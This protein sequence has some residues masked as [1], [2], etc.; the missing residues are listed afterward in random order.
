MRSIIG[1]LIVVIL[2]GCKTTTSTPEQA[3]ITPVSAHLLS[4]IEHPVAPLNFDIPSPAQIVE[5]SPEQQQHFL[6]YFNDP[7]R[8]E[9]PRHRRLFQYIDRLY[10]NFN[11]L[12]KTFDAETAMR[13]QSGNC[14]SLAIL[15]TALAELVGLDVGY[16][17]VNVAPVYQ[18]YAS[19][20]TLSTHVRTHL[21]ADAVEEDD[22]IVVLRARIIIDYYPQRSNIRGEMIDAPAF[23]SMYYRN[24][25]S[26]ALIYGRYN[27][28]Y[29]FMRY[30]LTIAPY[31][32]ENLNTMAVTLNKLGAADKALAVYA[33][34][35][36]TAET[37]LNVISN[38][39]DLL[40]TVDK[41]EQ[42]AQVRLQMRRAND[43]NPYRWL[44]NANRAI[45]EG[46]YFLARTLLNKAL[47]RAPY[48]HEAYFSLAKSYYLSDEHEKADEALQTAAKLAYLPETE[49]LYEAKRAVLS[50][51]EQ[52]G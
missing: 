34:A 13:E 20:M 5:L 28:A 35:T 26:D 24:L 42:A 44:D 32:P 2:S 19:V 38:Y 25:A 33:Y 18:R 11:Y 7:V 21:Y 48:L 27:E 4:I 16:Q 40:E 52:D 46:K 14:M 41:Q 15:T 17:R 3:K 6:R 50:A 8:A 30:A 47:E 37:S 12:G 23:F 49:R 43:D 1:I 10:V 51:V 45:N 29:E 31:D 22:E 36:G 9:V 39:A